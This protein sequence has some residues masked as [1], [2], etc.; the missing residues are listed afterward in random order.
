MNATDAAAQLTRL[1]QLL[2]RANGGEPLSLTAVAAELGCDAETLK[3]D[4]WAL[5]STED[6]AGHIDPFTVT[7]EDDRVAVRTSTVL[8]PRRLAPT[9]LRALELGLGLMRREVPAAQQATVDKAM[10][11]VRSLL[12]QYKDEPAVAAELDGEQAAGDPELL[13]L[14]REARRRRRKVRFTYAP[15]SG[16]GTPRV[17][18]PYATHFASGM[19]YCIAWCESRGDVRVFRLDRITDATLLD[20]EFTR[21]RGFTPDAYVKDG[22]V[23]T[24]AEA[25]PVLRVR[26]SPVVAPWIAERERRERAADGSLEAEYPLADRAW[27]VRHLLQYGAEVTVLAPADLRDDLVRALDGLLADG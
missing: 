15:S 12:V 4:L 20:D 24:A 17:V 2:P 27:A 18:A 22:R 7:L 26:Y 14:L 5:G 13:A 8:R 9:E 23:F 21:P 11:L 16:P 19:W 6:L 10:K 3:A 1:L 25:A